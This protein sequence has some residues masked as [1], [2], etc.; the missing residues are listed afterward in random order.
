[1]LLLIAFNLTRCILCLLMSQPFAFPC[2]CLAEAP[3]PAVLG[4]QGLIP[5][6]C[7]LS[8]TTWC[9]FQRALVA[10]GQIQQSLCVWSVSVLAGSAAPA[11]C[12]LIRPGETLTKCLLSICLSPLQLLFCLLLPGSYFS[13]QACRAY[14]E[15][16][17]TCGMVSCLVLQQLLF[18][19]GVR[20]A[21]MLSSA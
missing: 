13:V 3:S 4:A 21:E 6:G 2:S 8:F 17:G 10:L 7:G 14:S 16:E 5:R 9:W 12:N 18:N 15:V 19:I 20:S 1:M 11:V